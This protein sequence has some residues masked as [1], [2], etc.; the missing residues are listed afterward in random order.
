MFVIR[1]LSMAVECKLTIFDFILVISIV[2]NVSLTEN[3]KISDAR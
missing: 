1:L 3:S 2:D